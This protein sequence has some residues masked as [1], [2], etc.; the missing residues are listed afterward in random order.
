MSF[1]TFAEFCQKSGL[2]NVPSIPEG[3]YAPHLE[4]MKGS[5]ILGTTHNGYDVL[6]LAVKGAPEGQVSC[7]KGEPTYDSTRGVLMIFF[8]T[9]GVRYRQIVGVDHT[10][11]FTSMSDSIGWMVKMY[12]DES[13]QHTGGY[14][15]VC[16]NCP[17]LNDYWKVDELVKII[18]GKSEYLKLVE[19]FPAR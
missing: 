7:L 12:H 11:L 16:P 13:P 1:L 4:D 3:K 14:L 2:E 10:F 9:P 8:K 15:D 5:S 18:Q 6:A 17:V 19:D